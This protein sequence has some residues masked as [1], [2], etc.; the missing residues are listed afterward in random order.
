MQ[1]VYVTF[2]IDCV[3][4]YAQTCKNSNKFKSSVTE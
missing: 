2:I 1:K 4:Q 3:F